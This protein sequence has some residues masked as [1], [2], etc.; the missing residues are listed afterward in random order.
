MFQSSFLANDPQQSKAI[1]ELRLRNKELEDVKKAMLNILEDLEEQK[2]ELEKVNKELDG[3]V[4]IVSH[5]LRTPLRGISS[6]ITFLEEDYKDKLGKEGQEFIEEIR[7]GANRLSDLIDDLLTLSR[8][9]R[10]KNPY[11]TVNIQTLIDSVFESIKHD[12]K[13]HRV[14]LKIHD[15]LPTV[16]CD[17]VKMA[18]VF[19]NLINNAIKFSS[20]NNKEN[21]KI[22]IGFME[23]SDN[24]EFYVKDNGI[25]IDP[26]YHEQIFEVFRRLHTERE[27]EGTGVGLSIVKRVIDDHGGRIWIESQCGQG[28]CFYFTIPKR[29][30]KQA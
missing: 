6:F 25:G 30:V 17:R 29:L 26:Q 27:F 9:A 12:I 13:T 19:L 21:P 15:Q 10:I 2:T 24:F 14:S 22:E 28:A 7:N 3:F 5:D 23:R 18:Q 20:K 11:E 8:I 16:V 4:H 1:E